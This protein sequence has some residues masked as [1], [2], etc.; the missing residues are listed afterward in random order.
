[1]QTY[2]LTVSRPENEQNTRKK[3]PIIV[4]LM[5]KFRREQKHLGLA[6]L[7]MGLKIYRLPYG[8]PDEGLKPAFF[9]TKNCIAK[10]GGC[11]REVNNVFFVKLNICKGILNWKMIFYS[12]IINQ[13]LKSDY[14]I[15]KSEMFLKCNDS[16]SA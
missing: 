8:L 6:D 1:M 14:D 4:A 15:Q 2:L 5:Q 3:H 9:G 13:Q 10:N 16:E 7:N 12:Q 11:V